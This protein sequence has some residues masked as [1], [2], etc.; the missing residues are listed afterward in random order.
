LVTP[1]AG[2]PFNSSAS[3]SATRFRGDD[4]VKAAAD[5]IGSVIVGAT[6]NKPGAPVVPI[7]GR[8]P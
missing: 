4:P 2:C 3:C 1:V 6:N 5:K 8:V 7:K